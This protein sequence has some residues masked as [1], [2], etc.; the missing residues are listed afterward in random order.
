LP[1]TPA[2]QLARERA[3]HILSQRRFRGVSLP[4]PLTGFLNTIGHWFSPIGRWLA[5][6]GC[7]VSR[8]AAAVSGNGALGWSL[9]GVVL[10]LVLAVA[11]RIAG[12]RA[13]RA[14]RADGALGASDVEDWRSLEAQALAAHA[15]GDDD[16]AFRLRFRA[17]LVRL[18]ATGMLQRSRTMTARQLSMTLGSADFD[19]LAARHEEVAFA[20]AHAS[21]AELDSAAHT[22]ESLAGLAKRR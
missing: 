21:S 9:F 11:V 7:L 10:L 2:A 15:A 8:I 18:E 14:G 5:P 16:R 12:Q 3:T 4:H 20:A 1:P 19:A 13:A 17:G 6:I 22:W